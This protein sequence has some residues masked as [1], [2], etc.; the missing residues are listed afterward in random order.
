MSLLP[1]AREPVHS[2]QPIRSV[3]HTAQFATSESRTFEPS[4]TELS[5]VES[6]LGRWN[7][8]GVVLGLTMIVVHA[9]LHR[10]PVPDRPEHFPKL[11]P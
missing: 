6:E 4:Q 11:H 10:G 8:H 5:S 2:Q 7:T 3:Y 9:N 1:F